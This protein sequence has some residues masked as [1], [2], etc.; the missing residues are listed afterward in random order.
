VTSW[1]SGHARGD[2]RHPDLAPQL[3]LQRIHPESEIES[4]ADVGN[5]TGVEWAMFS[6]TASPDRQRMDVHI[7]Q[8]LTPAEF[9]QLVEAVRKEAVKLKSGWAAAVDLRGMWISDPFVN[10]QFRS[11]QD[12]L[13]SGKA[14]KIGTLLDSDPVK[15][16]LWQAG[17]QTRSNAL[18]RRF[19]DPAQWEQFLSES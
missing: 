6:A 14:G 15:M 16:R 9:R 13:L 1:R 19:R 2:A 8:A 4:A 5:E 18:T 3:F 11:L 10:E 7:D 17:T 12:A